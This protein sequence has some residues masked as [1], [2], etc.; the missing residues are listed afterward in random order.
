M[1]THHPLYL[2]EDEITIL[3]R[4]EKG[5]VFYFH[6][7]L[8]IYPFHPQICE[9]TDAPPLLTNNRLPNNRYPSISIELTPFHIIIALIVLICAFFIGRKSENYRRDEERKRKKRE[10]IARKHFL[11]DEEHFLAERARYYFMLDNPYLR[12]IKESDKEKSSEVANDY[13]QKNNL[14]ISQNVNHLNSSHNSE[15]SD[16]AIEK[17]S[18]SDTSEYKEKENEL[19]I[20]LVFNE[21]L[22]KI[23]D[24][25]RKYNK[26]VETDEKN[27]LVPYSSGKNENLSQLKFLM[28]DQFMSNWP[29]LDPKYNLTVDFTVIIENG[30][31]KSIN[32]K[33]YKNELSTEEFHALMAIII[34]KY[35]L[36]FPQLHNFFQKTIEEDHTYSKNLENKL[37][38]LNEENTL[39]ENKNSL[40]LKKR[41][42]L[43]S[44]KAKGDGKRYFELSKS[45][46]G[47]NSLISNNSYERS[48]QPLALKEKSENH[49]N[50]SKNLNIEELKQRKHFQFE[51][52]ENGRFNKVFNSL[53]EVGKGGF[54]EVYKVVHKIENI[55]YAIKKVYL[56][57]KVN[58][59]IRN[60]KYFREVMSMTKFN[61]KNV[62]RFKI[63]FVFL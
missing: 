29:L 30:S 47:N 4:T 1:K 55:V 23:F 26:K 13:N 58:E 61:H 38:N 20:S 37:N 52:F 28:D 39:E 27:A 36:K 42:S 50:N 33:N 2:E 53:Q 7:R 15:K 5:D 11:I 59:D 44:S 34:K 63:F 40:V 32:Y 9:I 35:S 56:P 51:L 45:K 21:N 49:S 17:S 22:K 62:I 48:F 60:H 10:K 18:E 54:G 12:F 46:K 24:E 41:K 8:H 3:R 43:E 31:I 16:R 25:H 6:E 14:E 19:S 57:L